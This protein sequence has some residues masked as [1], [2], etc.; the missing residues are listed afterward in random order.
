M[1]LEIS[2]FPRTSEEVGS[3]TRKKACR[4]A[5][6]PGLLFSEAEDRKLV[7]SLSASDGYF[8]SFKTFF[9]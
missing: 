4:H 9:V 5:F 1:F 2:K 7:T 3:G 6:G 8:S